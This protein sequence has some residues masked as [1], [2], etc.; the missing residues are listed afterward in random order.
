MY[1][2]FTLDQANYAIDIIGDM[3]TQAAG[4]EGGVGKLHVDTYQIQI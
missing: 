1:L 3:P 4:L 2:T